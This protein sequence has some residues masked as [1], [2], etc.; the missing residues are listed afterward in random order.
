MMSRLVRGVAL[1]AVSDGLM[2]T[3]GTAF[4]QHVVTEDEASKL[5]LEALT[6]PPPPPRPAYHIYRASYRIRAH[7]GGGRGF[8]ISSRHGAARHSAY[9][10]AAYHAGSRAHGAAS[11]HTRHAHR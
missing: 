1:L 2:G 7:H 10:R 3:A 8:T 9:V 5:T 4:A 6:A 11:R